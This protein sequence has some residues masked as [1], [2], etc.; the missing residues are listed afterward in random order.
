MAISSWVNMILPRVP[1]ASKALVEQEVTRTVENFCREATAWRQMVYGLH[2]NE[3][4]REVPILIDDGLTLEVIQIFRVYYERRQLTP[5]SHVPWEISTNSP[6]G[7]TAKSSDP[8]TIVLSTIPARELTDVLDAW[9]AVRPLNPVTND[10]MPIL[11]ST[12]WEYIFDGAVGRLYSQPA[13]P[14]TSDKLAQ[15][16]LA[17]YNNGLRLGLDQANRGF[18]GNAQNWVFPG[19]GR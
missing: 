6:T 10:N 8:S 18:T 14:Y 19:F 17:R 11:T 15:Y 5:Y 9:V 16:H 4:D 12:F 1:G 2:I 3:G 7:W 13:K